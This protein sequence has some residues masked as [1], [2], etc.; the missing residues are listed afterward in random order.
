MNNRVGS[1]TQFLHVLVIGESRFDLFPVK[2]DF[3][4]LFYSYNHFLTQD[5]PHSGLIFIVSFIIRLP[6]INNFIAPAVTSFSY[7]NSNQSQTR[8]W[9]CQYMMRRNKKE[10]KN[11]E[12][13]N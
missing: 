8:K 11:A 5:P 1:T 7:K 4:H 12:N 2:F 10:R 6:S 3:K 9:A 13:Q